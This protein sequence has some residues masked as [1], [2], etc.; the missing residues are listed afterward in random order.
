MQRGVSII[1]DTVN[2]GTK[3]D[4]RL[5]GPKQVDSG[6]PMTSCA[7]FVVASI[8]INTRDVDEH[9]DQI[10]VT[11]RAHGDMQRRATA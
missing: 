6:R 4:Q 3:A 8:H 1:V 9:C 7:T 11:L 5:Q 2:V 10:G